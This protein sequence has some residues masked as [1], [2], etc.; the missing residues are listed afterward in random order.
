MS[1]VFIKEIGSFDTER[2]RGEAEE[3]K[4]THLQLNECQGLLAAI[5][6]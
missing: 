1:S 6:N 5:R 3:I 2:H 4:V